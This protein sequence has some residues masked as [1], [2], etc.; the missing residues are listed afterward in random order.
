MKDKPNLKL[1]LKDAV[2]FTVREINVDSTQ[3]FPPKENNENK[4]NVFCGTKR[5]QNDQFKF[6]LTEEPSPRGWSK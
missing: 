2:S 6:F 3:V 1:Q 5:Q 4:N